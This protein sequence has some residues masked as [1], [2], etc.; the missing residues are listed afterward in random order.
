MLLSASPPQSLDEDRMKRRAFLVATAMLATATRQVM[1]AQQPA[2]IKRVASMHPSTKVEDQRIGS[3][4]PVFTFLL[5]EMKRLGYVEGVNFVLDRYSAEGQYDRN[6]EIAHNIVATRPDAILSIS[7]PVTSALVSETRTIPIVA[8]T[9]DPVFAGFVTN[10]ARAGGNITGVGIIVDQ[11]GFVSK[12]LQFL[13]EA[14]GRLSNVRGLTTNPDFVAKIKVD[15]EAVAEKLKIT[16]RFL[17]LQSPVDETGYRRVFE[18]MR[19]DHVDAVLIG[20]DTENYAHRVLL[21]RLAR[22]Y[23]LPAICSF[24]DS[25]EAGA[26]MA[27]TPR[28]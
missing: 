12:R 14:V 23:R 26:L 21:G 11:A 28:H 1:A 3:S 16:F 8:W 13:A 9:G 22:E 18:A 4:D 5:E 25:V 24:S 10:L 15:A 2:K 20:P 17:Q 19:R 7:N 6:P 27:Y